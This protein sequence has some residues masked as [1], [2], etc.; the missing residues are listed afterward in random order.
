MEIM[1]AATSVI[2]SCARTQTPPK[3]KGT[4]RLAYHALGPDGVRDG[5]ALEVLDKAESQ[6]QGR[7]KNQHV[8]PPQWRYAAIPDHRRPHQVRRVPATPYSHLRGARL[9][10]HLHSDAGAGR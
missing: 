8:Q 4:G 9:Q 6:R 10:R 2:R 1:T 3:P 5:T 7:G